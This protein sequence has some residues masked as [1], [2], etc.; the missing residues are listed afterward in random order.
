MN[1]LEQH[2]AKRSHFISKKIMELK[3]LQIIYV[4]YGTIY[5]KNLNMQN[6]PVYHLEK[7]TY[8]SSLKICFWM[9]TSKF[10]IRVPSGG[11]LERNTSGRGPQRTTIMLIVVNF[12][13]G[14]F[15]NTVWYMGS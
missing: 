3:N 6:D 2:L 11:D 12:G 1:K 5:A 15:P 4:Q 8:Y 7:F 14:R 10:R 13:A 9:I